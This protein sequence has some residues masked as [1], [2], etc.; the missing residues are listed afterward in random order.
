MVTGD[1]AGAASHISQQLQLDEVHANLLPQDK[2]HVIEH[3]KRQPLR[4]AMVG[5]GINDAPAF[6]TADL[7]IVMGGAG[8]D[9]VLETADIVLMA[10]NLNKLPYTLDLSKATLTIIKQNIAFSIFIKVVAM[11]L[12]FP[13]WLTLWMAV[14]SDTGAAVLVTL[15]A[16]RLLRKRQL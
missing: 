9:T 15:N 7:S 16:L 10:D 11:V 14:L 2:V 1:N 3:M 8:T 4:T 13:G 6:V 12:V 5:D